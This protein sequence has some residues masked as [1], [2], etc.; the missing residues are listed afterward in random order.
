MFSE[1]LR[2]IVEGD[3][4]HSSPLRQPLDFATFK[5]FRTLLS[6]F[7]GSHAPAAPTMAPVAVAPDRLVPALFEAFRTGLIAA[8]QGQ[9]LTFALDHLFEP[10]G[11]VLSD[12]A[13]YLRPYFLSHVARGELR[14]VRLIVTAT[15]SEYRDYGLETLAVG[16]AVLEIRKFQ[17]EEFMELLPEFLRFHAS[18]EESAK[19]AEHLGPLLK[20]T[21]KGPSDFRAIKDLVVHT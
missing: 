18:R 11:I 9:P 3:P 14:P 15:E 17:F 4:A 1:V 13:Q 2:L 21:V 8:S 5:E 19:I 7:P 12:F 16:D 6:A 20:K 10:G